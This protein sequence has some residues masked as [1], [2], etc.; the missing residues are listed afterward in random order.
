MT[1][2][3]DEHR[4]ITV[5]S[6]HANDVF[7]T[8]ILS[9]GDNSGRIIRYVYWD[10]SE[11]A[12]ITGLACKFTINQQGGLYED[13]TPVIGEPTATWECSPNCTGLIPGVFSG[14]FIVTDSNDRVIE[15]LP[16]KIKISQGTFGAGE[17]GAEMQSAL[18]EFEQRAQD[19][20]D[21]ANDAVTTA[22]TITNN[23]A[24][25]YSDGVLSVT[26]KT[27]HT[28]TDDSIATAINRANE[29]V[30]QLEDVDVESATAAAN[31]AADRADAAAEAVEE[32]SVLGLSVVNG[33]VCQ[34][35]LKEV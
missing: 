30:T 8:I 24:V 32:L 14:S 35:Y 2:L 28:E 12:D 23:I 26:D 19:A 18:S 16:G 11:P 9:N 20:L 3:V 6:H 31:K 5:V 15:S 34:T 1:T 29:L 27:G 25:S 7:Q 13:M 33:Q 10:G 17:S 22:N 21:N 4:R